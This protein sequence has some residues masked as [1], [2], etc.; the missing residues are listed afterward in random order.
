MK[1]KSDS[2]EIWG[3]GTE[4]RDLIYID[5]LTSLMRTG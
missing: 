3:D 2:V 4:G 5:D 1:N